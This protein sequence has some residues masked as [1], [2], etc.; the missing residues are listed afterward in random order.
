MNITIGKAK[1]ADV[2]VALANSAWSDVLSFIL[3]L[4][5]LGP[6]NYLL[7][8]AFYFVLF[9]IQL[10]FFVDTILVIVLILMMR[11][12][13]C[14][15]LRLDLKIKVLLVYMSF[16]ASPDMFSSIYLSFNIADIFRLWAQSISWGQR[17][18]LLLAS[19]IISSP[20][21]IHR[22]CSA[23][24]HYWTWI[25][26]LFNVRHIEGITLGS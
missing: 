25:G 11:L 9:F 1:T 22:Y 14:V 7:F 6:I 20:W 10:D 21:L 5:F 13:R 8:L 17:L 18:L 15:L 16:I 12:M 23:F 26:N 3:S 24:F 4:R 2:L 19:I